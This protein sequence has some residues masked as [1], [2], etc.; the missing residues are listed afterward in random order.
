MLFRNW[1]INARIGKGNQRDFF[2]IRSSLR[3]LQNSLSF[4]RVYDKC[5]LYSVLW[6]EWGFRYLSAFFH[7]RKRWK[8][9]R[10]TF[11][12]SQPNDF[13]FGAENIFFVRMSSGHSP[14]VG[15]KC[16]WKRCGDALP[17]LVFT[18]F[19]S[20]HWPKKDW[21]IVLWI[22]FYAYI[23]SFVFADAVPFRCV[24]WKAEVLDSW[25]I[26]HSPISENRIFPCA[27]GLR[28]K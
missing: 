4:F 13:S 1:I 10:Q 23:P 11:F 17:R 5:L 24:L 2:P 7:C 3:V 14:R 19:G 27:S 12:Q 22:L 9:L 21:Q 15:W 6:T 18:L 28:N 25:Q 16:S 20:F 8:V 26:V